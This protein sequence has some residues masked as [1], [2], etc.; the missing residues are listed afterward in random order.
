MIK[1]ASVDVKLQEEL[2]VERV[3]KTPETPGGSMNEF[4]LMDE[5][6]LDQV[7]KELFETF[8]AIEALTQRFAD[9]IIQIT[10]GE[11]PEPF[12]SEMLD[13]VN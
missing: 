3:T 9:N 2:E 1:T 5:K 12:F 10:A 8:S 11:D 13:F 4:R 7:L 6:R